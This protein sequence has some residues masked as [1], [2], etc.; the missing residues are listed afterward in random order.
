MPYAVWS[1]APSRGA[2][3]LR[4]APL[5]W[6]AHVASGRKSHDGRDPKTSVTLQAVLVS[7]NAGIPDVK[8]HKMAGMR[9]HVSA[10]FVEKAVASSGPCGMPRM[11]QL[12][13]VNA[14]S[15]SANF[16]RRTSLSRAGSTALT[17]SM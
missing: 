16:R 3:E 10:I 14:V 12:P 1:T 11:D 13:R 9:R 17:S 15:D 7:L 4:P 6:T 2:V 8:A 5:V